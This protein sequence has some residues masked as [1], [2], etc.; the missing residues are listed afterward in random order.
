[1]QNKLKTI[2]GETLMNKPLTPIRFLVQSLIPQGLHILAGAPKTGKSWLALWLCLQVA[3]G[4][5]VWS[6]RTEKGTTLYLCLEDSESRIQNRLFD[7]T[8]DGPDNAHFTITSSAIGGGL[9]R[10]LENFLVEHPDTNFIVIDTLQ[11]IRQIS[12]DNAYAND[13]RDLSVLKSAADK[14][15]VAILLIHHLR[16][17]SDDDPINMISSTTGLTGAVD[18]MYIIKKE[19][20]R[21]RTAS[22]IATGRDI[23]DKEF[24]LDFDKGSHVWNFVS[25]DSAEPFSFSVDDSLAE[26]IDFIKSKGLF[27]G[28]ASELTEKMRTNTRPNILSKKLVQNQML[29]S[30]MGITVSNSRTGKR[31]ELTIK[32]EL[33]FGDSNDGNDG[34]NDMM[35]IADLLSQP[36]LPSQTD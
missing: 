34:K 31:R 7:I 3:K 12:N 1:M 8:D 29:L 19:S 11:K 27:V 24:T 13:Y 23:E 26:I 4:E 17:Q 2:D 15:S 10:Q 14:L 36:S 35:G 30:D 32:Y 33:P 18:G 21:S 5:D 16:K 28:T 6:F 25:D 20:R 9:E 22:F